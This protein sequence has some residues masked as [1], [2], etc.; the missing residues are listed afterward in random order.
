MK[1]YRWP[2]QPFSQSA[3]PGPTP[4]QATPRA[5]SPQAALHF[6]S[7]SSPTAERPLSPITN[8]K[9][10][11]PVTTSYSRWAHTLRITSTTVRARQ[12][13]RSVAAPKQHPRRRRLRAALA[14]ARVALHG[15][16]LLKR[17]A[18]RLRSHAWRTRILA[19]LLRLRSLRLLR[20]VLLHLVLALHR[21]APRRKNQALPVQ[22]RHKLRPLRHTHAMRL[23]RRLRARV[24]LRLHVLQQRSYRHRRLR[25]PRNRVPRAAMPHG[26][27]K[28][29]LR[30]LPRPKLHAQR[31]ALHFPV[32][33][34]PPG[35]VVVAQVA[36]R[37][38]AALAQL[39]LQ[40]PA[41][42]K[43][44]LP[45]ILRRV[46]RDPHRDDDHLCRRNARRHHHAAVVTVHHDHHADHTRRQP[47]A[48]LPRDQRLL[49]VLRVLEAD[50]EHLAEVLPQVVAR[51]A[52]A[53]APNS[54]NERLHRRRVVPASEL[55]LL[56]LA[57]AH[58]RHRQKLLVHRRIALQDVQH[59]LRALLRLRP[60]A[61]PL[62]PQE[63]ASPNERRRVREL[64]PDHV[65]PHVQ[66]HGQ[67]AVRANPLRVVRVHH[68]LARRPHSHRLLQ[69]RVA[70]ARH[71]CNLRRKALDMVLLPLQ[72][73]ARH[74]HRE[75]AVLHA[76]LLDLPPKKP[77]H[78]LPHVVC[79]GT[80]NVA[81]GHVVVLDHL[82]LRDHIDVP[83]REVLLAL[84]R[85]A[86]LRLARLCSRRRTSSSATLR[87]SS[88]RGYL[89]RLRSR[90]SR[91]RS[92]RAA[93]HRSIG[94]R[95]A[96]VHQLVRIPDLLEEPLELLKNNEG[97]LI[98]AARV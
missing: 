92:S 11:N 46:L 12:R 22:R 64:P 33:E 75:V 7:T 62:L 36:L 20:A 38:H 95:R 60:R 70:S 13:C 8:N 14:D 72:A 30:K 73:A 82:R 63:L 10:L 89:L 25:I 2:I 54:L 15:L 40:P 27:R 76:K 28:R 18:Q 37:A 74:E 81:P 94:R 1:E 3:S 61:V 44:L 79:P 90:S 50:V 80:D 66:P 29:P 48:V 71:P 67:V 97:A 49:V 24:H 17:D 52:L 45:R 26:H 59:L 5:H 21:A 96:K 69:L 58:H 32:V 86:E 34:P 88:L 55:L 68:R 84:H 4:P 9:S 39:A 78:A 93:R 42:C 6:Y 77:L 16:R 85:D 51:R 35:A 47:P 91:S 31:H 57:P 98:I 43:Q 83:R 65:V 23:H 53:P 56:R 41:A 19:R 87:R